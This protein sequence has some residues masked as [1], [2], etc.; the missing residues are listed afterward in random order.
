MR[1]FTSLLD[2]EQKLWPDGHP[3]DQVPPQA[4]SKQSPGPALENAGE[5]TGRKGP[6]IKVPSGWLVVAIA[7]VEDIWEVLCRKKSGS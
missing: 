5:T 7:R 6:P 3:D 4:I 2:A 1:E